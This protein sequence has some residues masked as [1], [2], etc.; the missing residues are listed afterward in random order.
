MSNVP[1]RVQ[2]SR[3]HQG[4]ER[5]RRLPMPPMT[6]SAIFGYRERVRWYEDFD[7]RH[8]GVA[9][10]LGVKPCVSSEK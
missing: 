4:R 9:E 10:Q 2:S 8:P 1:E 6:P 3:N 5:R 7:R